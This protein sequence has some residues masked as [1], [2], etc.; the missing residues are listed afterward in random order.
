MV[1]NPEKKKPPSH[2]STEKCKLKENIIPVN[3]HKIVGAELLFSNI[4]SFIHLHLLSIIIEPV[5]SSSAP[6][7]QKSQAITP[8]GPCSITKLCSLYLFEFH[9]F[10]EFICS[11]TNVCTQS[12]ALLYI[13]CMLI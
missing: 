2:Y 3:I 6:P 13:F 1:N 12:T 4:F 5:R 10:F 11:Y 9:I 8:Q 7:A